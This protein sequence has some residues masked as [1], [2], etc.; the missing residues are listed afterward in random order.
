MRLTRLPC[1]A[2]AAW[3]LAAAGA[4]AQTVVDIEI[5]NMGHGPIDPAFVE[6]HTRTRA[7]DTLDRLAVARDVR[8]LLDTG[9]FS[10]VDA[11]VQPE[12]EGVAL[13]FVLER[14]LLLARPVAFTGSRH[15]RE[16]KLR[17]LVD[18]APGDR[19]DDHILGVRARAIE[20]AFIDDYYPEV[21][22]T[23]TIELEDL[24]T[25]Q[26]AVAM[27][28]EAGPRRKVRR[29]V[30]EG[31]AAVS[32]AAL[33]SVTRR[34]P[35]YHPLW[36]FRKRR[37]SPDE[38]EALRL[39]VRETYRSRGYLDASVA[40]P[41]VESDAKGREQITI[42]IE[43]G[44]AYRLD[45]LDVTG[46]ER[47][48]AAE[49][50]RLLTA[51]PGAAASSDTI[52]AM[53]GS[54]RDFYHS[55]GYVRARVRPLLEADPGAGTV[56]ITYDVSEGERVYVGNV[57]IRG[58][59]RTR[60]KVI[61]RELLVY[62]GEV[63][64]GVR[65]RRS[66]RRLLNLGFFSD[67]RRYELP[68]AVPNREDL[69]FEVE[70]KRTGQFMIGAG[71]SSVDNLIGFLE[72]SQGNFDLAGWPAFTGGGQKLKLRA[73]FGSDRQDY[74]L[75]FV[76]P[77]FLDRRLS[78]GFDLYLND[79]SYSDYELR[80]T[81]A[82]VSLTRPL[83][84]PNRLS[85]RYALE[86]TEITDV[87]DTNAYLSVQTGETYFFTREDEQRLKSAL[88]VTL[89]HDSRN[90]AFIP[91]RGLRASLYG[92]LAGGPLGCD[93]DLYELGANASLY[94]PLWW[95]HVLSL[96]ARYTVVDAYDDTGEVPITDRLFAG[97]GRTIRGYGY[98]D[99]G[100][101]VVPADATATNAAAFR[102]LGGR[103]MAVANVE[104]TVPL[105]Q[106]LRLA[107]FYDIG[108]VW[109]D[110]FTYNHNTLAS[111][112]GVGL[113][114]D[115]PGFPMRIDYAWALDPDDELTEEDNW[116]FWIGYDY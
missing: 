54:I 69:V 55:R 94:V 72:L 46:V 79:I 32:D 80:R 50:E 44:P 99:V 103:S 52:E 31:N 93:T 59:T 90:D 48:P 83:P 38:L 58:N 47:F 64:D 65:A 45:A 112:A 51:T 63:L 9:R 81:G 97:G 66:E 24:E 10:M 96:K 49:L 11:D 111:S 70:E 75:S 106:G 39:A 27:Q 16:G 15:L 61:R 23:W 2:L 74:E 29:V 1:A 105:T 84:G 109:L 87:A 35:W 82:A 78:L 30:F 12:G 98:R 107:A 95:K 28:I 60:D 89:T 4:V 8:A 57:R 76:E 25:G 18:L 110:P 85:F 40:A 21:A 71:F 53:A 42:G 102:P 62:P 5:R 88:R 26:A 22:V 17:D 68:T 13:T 113:R 43:E 37:Y 114:L 115:I 41:L 34:Y 92:E 20:R 3:L 36:L 77:W 6:A 73:Q 101:K 108:G 14:R 33:R 67:V 116:V 91:S 56:K 7:G 100:P 86:E 19:V 104:Y